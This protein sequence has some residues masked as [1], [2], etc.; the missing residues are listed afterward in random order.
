MCK[1]E[2]HI[3][4]YKLCVIQTSGFT[5][6]IQYTTIMMSYVIS[7]LKSHGTHKHYDVTTPRKWRYR[8]NFD[9]DINSLMGF[10]CCIMLY[11]FIQ[12]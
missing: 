10:R 9:V 7:F 12:K 8:I 5:K 3:L 11:D 2:W 1:L 6:S 4:H